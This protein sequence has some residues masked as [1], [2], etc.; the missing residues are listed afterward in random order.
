MYEA[1]YRLREKPFSILRDPDLIYWGRAHRMEFSM[2]EFGVLNNAQFTVGIG[3]D[4]IGLVQTIV[5]NF[6]TSIG[7]SLTNP[8]EDTSQ[9]AMN[10]TNYYRAGVAAL[11]QSP[12][13][14][15]SAW[16]NFTQAYVT[17]LKLVQ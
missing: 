16:T 12:P 5:A 7:V 17:G 6:L 4:Q 15:K 10:A 2:L 9:T 11:G 3:R 14:Y 8:A 13:S 1:F